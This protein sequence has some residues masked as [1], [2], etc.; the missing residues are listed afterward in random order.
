MQ[1]T[2][3]SISALKFCWRRDEGSLTPLIAPVLIWG[4]DWQCLQWVCLHKIP[5]L[6]S[7][8]QS[9]LI[10]VIRFHCVQ[11]K[12]H[13]QLLSSQTILPH[14]LKVWSN[15]KEDVLGL[16]TPLG[17]ASVSAP[18]HTGKDRLAYFPLFSES[19]LW[20]NMQIENWSQLILNMPTNRLRS[21][22]QLHCQS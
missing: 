21:L 12:I 11:S 3:T 6:A 19:S 9:P 16:F 18:V 8:I 7:V 22:S 4:V 2:G 13:K 17:A 5:P 1:S 15:N 10:H 14:A 20:G